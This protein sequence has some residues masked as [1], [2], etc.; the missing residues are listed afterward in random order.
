[1]TSQP[2]I[3]STPDRFKQVLAELA[4][5]PRFSLDIESDSF[6]HYEER[7]CIV[8]L[9]TEDRNV[10]IDTLA[11]GEA[12][13]E[14]QQLVGR[15]DRPCLMHSASNDV[16][17]LKRS[18]K[19]EFGLIQDTAMAGSLLGFAQTGLATLVETFIGL[20]L[21]KDLQRYDWGQRPLQPVHQEYLINDTR[22]LFKV[23]DLIEE[24]LRK[25]DIVDE[26][27][28]EC[29]ALALSL[30]RE[31]SFDP[32]RFRRIKGHEQLDAS[33]RGALKSLY[34]W[35]DR[36]ARGLNRAPFRVVSD[37]AL[38]GL[39]AE[40]PK[41]E[42]ELAS[43]SGIGNWLSSYVAEMLAA[44]KKGLSEPSPPRAPRVHHEPDPDNKPLDMRQRDILGKLKAWREQEAKARGLG[45]QAIMP[46]PAFHDLVHTPPRNTEELGKLARVGP[47]R[48]KRYGEP[49]LALLAPLN[50]R[51]A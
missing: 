49:L 37:H 4:N 9:S 28:I 1:M 2:E 26:Y 11:L 25:A 24:Q 31:R 35:R 38:M 23:H 13:R 45:L 17:A 29:E 22:H 33:R 14:L 27:R 6:Y 5:A 32:E 41:D 15:R 43:R 48:A 19:L 16:L 39:A 7:V 18:F 50:K 36:T 34:A 42:Q 10:I 20:R 12:S 3:V 30:P 47:S 46:T 40:P 21:P 8:T 44:L 51:R